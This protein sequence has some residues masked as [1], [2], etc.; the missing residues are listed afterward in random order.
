MSA[1]ILVTGG[2]GYIG[3]HVVLQ[4]AESGYD[5]V[6]YDNCST[7]T[8]ESVLHGELVVGDLADVDRLYQIFS[9]HKFSAVLHFAATLVVPESVAH[10]LDYYANN[11]RN[12]LNLLRC[13]SVMGVNQFVFSS[14]A[15]VYGQPQENP[16]TEESPTLPINPYG[17]SKLMSEWIIQDYGLASNFRYVILRYF[18]VAGSDSKGRIGSNLRNKHHLIANACNVALNSEPELKIFGT[19]FPTIDGTGVR[20]YIHVEDLAGAHV[21]ALKYLE[22]NGKSQIL[23]C[24]YGKGYSVLQVIER[25]KAISG[26]DFPVV[27]AD[28]RPGDPACVTADARKIKEVLNW[29]PKHEDLDEIIASTIDWEKSR[30]T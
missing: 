14:T 5:I 7:G 2:A 8:P 29:Q 21:D 3:S 19:D 28:P 15:A 27:I 26:R 4:L 9:Q 13:C 25:V 10:P 22:N 1:K 18:N 24:G 6:V 30:P 20:D 23:N 16:V 11:T 12:T 17:R